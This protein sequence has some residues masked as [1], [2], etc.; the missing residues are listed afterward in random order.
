M[1][2]CGP[3]LDP[4]LLENMN[5]DPQSMEH[6]EHREYIP[7]TKDE[8]RAMKREPGFATKYSTP[9]FESKLLMLLLMLMITIMII[10]YC[11][12]EWVTD[13]V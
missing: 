5:P 13:V 4:P 3:P 9:A 8:K 2:P 12:I 1:A 11:S 10:V 7:D 6:F